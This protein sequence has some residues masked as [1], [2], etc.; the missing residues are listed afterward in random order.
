MRIE[1]FASPSLPILLDHK[2]FAK[3]SVR[4]EKSYILTHHSSHSHF[5]DLLKIL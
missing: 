2:K 4:V 5:E 3:K 1:G